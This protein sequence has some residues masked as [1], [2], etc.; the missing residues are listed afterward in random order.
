MDTATDITQRTLVL[1][2]TLRAPRELVFDVWSDPKHV[3]RW[4]GPKDFTLPYCE[5][6]FRVGGAYRFCMR[7]PDGSDHWVRGEY[8]AI[9]RPGRL[10]FTWL[11]ED[12]EGEVWCDNLVT[13]TLEE[14]GPDTLLTLH[15]A[16]FAT[17]AHCAEHGEGWGECLD[18]LTNYVRNI[19]A[20]DERTATRTPEGDLVITRI[21]NAARALVWKAW[22]D[23]AQFRRWW[24][25]AIYSAPVAEMDVRAGGRYRWCMRS[26]EGEEYWTAGVFCEVVPPDRLVYTDG[27]AD[28]EGNIVPAS[29]Y[30]MEG[31]WPEELLVTV[32]LE[33][34]G[35]R[36]RMVLRHAGIPSGQ[37]ND[38]TAQGWNESLDKLAAAL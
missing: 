35:D 23:P 24:G 13:I 10:V 36:T 8:H 18:R 3:V 4:W 1:R 38:L 15:H 34:L 19:G 30:G 26:P 33:D 11:R 17:E 28:A 27:F 9:E 29:H 32:T 21:F 7:A 31:E 2:R 5:Q 16:V 25:P 22:T 20:Q 37:W 6:D 14:D 12:E